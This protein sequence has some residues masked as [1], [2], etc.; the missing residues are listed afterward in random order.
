MSYNCSKNNIME[1]WGKIEITQIDSYDFVNL[2]W[3]M[4]YDNSGFVNNMNIILEAY[5]NDYLYGLRVIE[6][7]KMYEKRM[8]YN[9]IF[10]KNSF[11]LLPC[12]CIKKENK[13]LILWVHNRARKMGFGRKLVELLKIDTVSNILPDSKVFWEKCGVNIENVLEN[14]NDIY[15][16][17]I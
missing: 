2:F 7:D 17:D 5:K 16:D 13:V 4:V 6:N 3:E 12:F 10:C 1:D 14:D 11:Y 9:P 8:R 15:I